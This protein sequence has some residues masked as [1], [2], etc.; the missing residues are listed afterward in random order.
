MLGIS[1]CSCMGGA[2]VKMGSKRPWWASLQ[3]REDPANSSGIPHGSPDPDWLFEVIQ[4]DTCTTSVSSQRCRDRGHDALRYVPAAVITTG[5][6]SVI[7][8]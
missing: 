5:P 3:R 6:R 8:S 4:K 2:A 1:L 7:K